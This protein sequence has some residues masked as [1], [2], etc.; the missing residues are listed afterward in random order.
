MAQRTGLRPW[1]L[2]AVAGFAVLTLVGGIWLVTNDEE[3]A[4]GQGGAPTSR[5]LQPVPISSYFAHD[6]TH[7]SLTYAI[8][9]P[10]CYGRVVPPRM[11]ETSRAVYVTLL[12][13]PVTRDP[14]EPCADIAKIESVRITLSS[15]LGARKVRDASYQGSVVPVGGRPGTVF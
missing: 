12:R 15:P 5:A 14:A 2:P 4:P 11:R 13:R 8:G 7:L 6:A 1:L 10:S 3:H 9:L